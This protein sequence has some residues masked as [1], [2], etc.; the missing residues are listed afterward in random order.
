MEL[1]EIISH[2]K[3]LFLHISLLEVIKH[4]YV[5]IDTKNK[6]IWCLINLTSMEY[7]PFDVVG[8]LVSA[9]IIPLL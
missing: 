6:A 3:Q 4:V 1:E 9:D 8:K 5:R 2:L 7:D